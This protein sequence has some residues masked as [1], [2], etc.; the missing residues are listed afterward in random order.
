MRAT[1]LSQNL[2]MNV[3]YG[4]KSVPPCV[5]GLRSEGRGVSRQ[6]PAGPVGQE[7]RMAAA[8]H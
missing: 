8:K 7:D 5:F 3:H 6:M 1:Q 4:V 2:Q